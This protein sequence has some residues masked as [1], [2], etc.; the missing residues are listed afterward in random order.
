MSFLLRQSG[1]KCTGILS[2]KF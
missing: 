1:K 2:A